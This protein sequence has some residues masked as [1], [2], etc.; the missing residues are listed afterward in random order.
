M[1]SYAE[2]EAYHAKKMGGRD[3]ANTIA[4][5]PEVYTGVMVAKTTANE[6]DGFAGMAFVDVFSDEPGLHTDVMVAEAITNE[7]MT[8]TKAAI[9]EAIAEH[10][11]HTTIGEGME[12]NPWIIDSGCSAHFSP[13]WSEFI[14]YAP[15]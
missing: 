11:V 7:P 3:L 4:N 2:R 14:E 5:E 15:Y 8:Y 12:L 6:P 10:Y 1:A 13:N 9:T